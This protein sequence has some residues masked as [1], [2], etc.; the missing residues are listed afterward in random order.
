MKNNVGVYWPTYKVWREELGLEEANERTALLVAC[1]VLN[2]LARW[3]D[4]EQKDEP[5]M[6]TPG[7]VEST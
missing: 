4:E 6:I 2:E 5:V 7:F 3:W 1:P